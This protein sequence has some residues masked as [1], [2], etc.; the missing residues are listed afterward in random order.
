[1]NAANF[2]VVKYRIEGLPGTKPAP[3]A[4]LPGPLDDPQTALLP[5]PWQP[6]AV[7]HRRPPHLQPCHRLCGHATSL[8]EAARRLV[9]AQPTSPVFVIAEAGTG[10]ETD[11]VT[12]PERGLRPSHPV[13]WLR[14]QC[15]RAI[16]GR[17]PGPGLSATS[18]AV[19]CTGCRLPG[20]LRSGLGRRPALT[21]ADGSSAAGA[22]EPAR[23]APVELQRTH[24]MDLGRPGSSSLPVGRRHVAGWEAGR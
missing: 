20:Q 11:L 19:C 14:S 9:A 21:R 8:C 4:P 24:R 6:A 2:T 22:S 15:V 7:P 5:R 1:M 23:V 13:A 16:H 12:T 17:P 18:M 10:C 3:Y